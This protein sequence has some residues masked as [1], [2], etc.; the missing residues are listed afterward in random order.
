MSFRLLDLPAAVR[1][2]VYRDI[3]ISSLGGGIIV[4]DPAGQEIPNPSTFPLGG[5]RPSQHEL[6]RFRRG[7]R[8]RNRLAFLWS[9][10]Q[11]Y[12]E[13]S[14][15]MYEAMPIDLGFLWTRRGVAEMAE[16]SYIFKRR[17]Q[18]VQHLKLDA[19]AAEIFLFRPGRQLQLSK[20]PRNARRRRL[21][22]TVLPELVKIRTLA[23]NLRSVSVY[24]N[25]RNYML[26]RAENS[27]CG[28]VRLAEPGTRRTLS[29]LF[30]RIDDIV[31]SNDYGSERFRKRATGVWERY[32]CRD[33]LEW[34]PNSS[35]DMRSLVH[36][37]TG[38]SLR[39]AATRLGPNTARDVQSIQI[40][41]ERSIGSMMRMF[42]GLDDL[43]TLLT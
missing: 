18:F 29:R 14:V 37:L 43:D 6:Y 1:N 19:T 25:P 31:F 5:V 15:L 17:I 36:P 20:I 39:N 7:P 24:T 28:M 3:V 34:N 8:C 4:A 42:A 12:D 2:I 33:A 38:L 35:G 32:Y 11:V 9:C 26:R 30:P 16:F 40:G 41:Q 10:A 27:M 23:Y 22:M 21:M 13:L